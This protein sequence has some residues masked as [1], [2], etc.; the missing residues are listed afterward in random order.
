MTRGYHQV[1]KFKN[2]LR[3]IIMYNIKSK[4][5]RNL[6]LYLKKL[7]TYHVTHAVHVVM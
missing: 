4:I 7:K 1:L 3:K 2:T 6:I 5:G